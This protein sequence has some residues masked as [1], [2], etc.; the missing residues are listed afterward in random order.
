MDYLQVEFNGKG[1]TG[2]TFGLRA[3]LDTKKADEEVKALAKT[4]RTFLDA[5]YPNIQ[6]KA[7]RV[8]HTGPPEGTYNAHDVAKPKRGRARKVQP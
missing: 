4:V 3:E 7:A 2:E 5:M 1:R 8:P 6:V